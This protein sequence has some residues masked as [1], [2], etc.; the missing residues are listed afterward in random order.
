MAEALV[1]G[2]KKFTKVEEP[3]HGKKAI[4]IAEIIKRL[5]ENP[6]T[7]MEFEDLANEVGCKWPQDLL[8]AMHALE[9]CEFIDRYKP[10][11]EAGK[12]GNAFYAWNGP[13]DPSTASGQH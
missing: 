11:T 6:G 3:P 1:V 5:Q 12:R 7:P 13:A 9:M 10:S 2:D 4:Q 8:A